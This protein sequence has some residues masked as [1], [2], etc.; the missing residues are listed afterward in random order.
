[1]SSRFDEAAQ[2]W[3]SNPVR[4]A[5][6]RGIG[7]AIQRTVPIQPSWH[8]LDYGAGTGLLTLSLLPRVAS[9]TAFDS[10]KG[11]LE[12]L[13]KKVADAQIPNVQTRL[14]NLETEPYADQRFDLVVSSMTLHHLRDVPL[15]FKRLAALLNPGGWLALAD[16]DTE[17]GS[18]HGPANDVFHHGFDRSAIIKWLTDSGVSGISVTDAFTVSKP[19]ATG[20]MRNYSV[21]LA[22]GRL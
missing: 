9:V 10:S 19:S 3:D 6:A 14:W 5:L 20:E 1:M 15:V 17:D 13:T 21:F 7:E 4:V 2:Q 22:A 11:M 16:L 18:F 12:Q 8:A